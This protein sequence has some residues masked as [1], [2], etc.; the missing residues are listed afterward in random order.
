MRTVYE[1][2]RFKNSKEQDLTKALI[3]YSHNIEPF[4]RTDTRE[5]I[6]WLDEYPRRFKDQFIILGL[7]LNNSI[8]GFAQ[9]AYFKEVKLIFVDYIVIQKESRGNNTFYEFV[10]E[11]R[12][13]LIT[14]NIEF[15]YIL[16]EVGGFD[17][18]KEPAA[19]TRNL[20]RLL[21]MIG[22]GVIKTNYFHPRLGKNNYESEFLSVLMLYSPD[23]KKSIKKETFFLLLDTI[24]FNH[25]K[26]WYDVFFDE[27]TK[28][29][30]GKRLIKLVEKNHEELR[31]KDSV[32]VNGYMNIYTT[33]LLPAKH[34]SYHKLAK[35]AAVLFLF[36]ILTLIFGIIHKIVK[37]KYGIDTNAQVYIVLA[38]AFCLLFILL[39][40]TEKKTQSITSVIEKFLKKIKK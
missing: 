7:Y 18:N 6:Y 31:K 13:F 37:N 33:G 35:G 2:K 25:Y 23:E 5:I 26:R 3:I 29:E 16:A 10:E 1:L 36:I 40:L 28:A 15:D 21:K 9:L 24:Y 12:T 39:L 38:S 19:S 8:I 22:F 4:L 14:E 34:K 20:I 17:E 32:E 30:Y 11:I 27:K